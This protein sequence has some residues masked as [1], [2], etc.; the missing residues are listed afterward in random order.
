MFEALPIPSE[1]EILSSKKQVYVVVSSMEKLGASAM[2][3]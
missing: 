2:F 1:A 3:N